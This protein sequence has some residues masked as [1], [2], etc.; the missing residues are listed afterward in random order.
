MDEWEAGQRYPSWEQLEALSRLTEF[1]IEFFTRAH[2]SEISSGFMC[3]RSGRGRGCHP[4]SAPRGPQQF[5]REVV[6]Q[7]PG[8]R[9]HAI[10][11]F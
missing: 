5:P 10:T 6:A 8:T 3:L 1:P 7:T 9:W 2:D 4:L 11:L